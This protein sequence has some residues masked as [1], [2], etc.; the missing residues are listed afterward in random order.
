MC[1]QLEAQDADVADEVYEAYT[2]LLSRPED[3]DET[4]CFK[5]YALVGTFCC[6]CIYIFILMP[7]TAEVP[8][9]P[10]NPGV[11]R[12]YRQNPRFFRFVSAFRL[13]LSK[14]L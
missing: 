14:P 13:I 12:I 6:C 5:S 9:V 2:D 4:L 11:S 8:M 1:L 3:E 7:L 10:E